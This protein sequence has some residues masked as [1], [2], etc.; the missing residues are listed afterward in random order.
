MALIRPLRGK[1]P[2]IGPGTFVAETAVIIGDVT[3]GES[4]SIWYHAV[5]RGDVHFIRIGNR[6]NI[7][8]GAIL[9]CTYQRAPLEIGEEVTIGHGAIVH[10]CRIG[11]RVLVGMGAI[12]LDHAEVA[13]EV[14]IA[15][16]A[17]VPQGARLESGYLYA[18]IPARPIRLLSPEQI[19]TLR[20]SAI[21]YIGYKEWYEKSEL[22]ET[23]PVLREGMDVAPPGLEPGS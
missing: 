10:G 12:I 22:I 8:D 7:Q 2:Q 4:C 11:N 9:H 23:H 19:E 3:I 20:E 13:D 15:A 6:T 14:L 17:L 21:R 5:I 1:T 18:G 16:G